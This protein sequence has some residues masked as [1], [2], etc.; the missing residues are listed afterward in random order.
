MHA[1]QS[2][3]SNATLHETACGFGQTS[4]PL[5]VV[6][7]R[8]IPIGAIHAQVREVRAECSLDECV[9]AQPRDTGT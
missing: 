7:A 2:H 6:L 5:F 8:V 1:S 4:E 9:D 3:L